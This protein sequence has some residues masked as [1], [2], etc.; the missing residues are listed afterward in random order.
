MVSELLEG[1]ALSDCLGLM[2]S[3][4]DRAEAIDRMTALISWP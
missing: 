2:G 4:E 3:V 1:R